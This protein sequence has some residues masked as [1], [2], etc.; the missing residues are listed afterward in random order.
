M[1]VKLVEANI[2][3]GLFRLYLE[4][5]SLRQLS[6]WLEKNEVKSP[7]CK[8]KWS[9]EAISKILSN[10]KYTGNVL[11]KKTFVKDYIEGKQITNSGQKAKYYISNTHEAIISEDFNKV[12]EEKS[13]RR[14]RE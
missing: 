6:M 14:C 8:H 3:K 13:R 4:G 1:I 10:E 9:I 5:K 11:L 12:Q 2:V 7:K